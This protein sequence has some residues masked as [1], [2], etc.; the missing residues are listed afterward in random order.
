MRKVPQYVKDYWKTFV[1]P[2]KSVGL[3]ESTMMEIRRR[4]LIEHAFFAKCV[5]YTKFEPTVHDEMWAFWVQKTGADVDF[6]TFANGITETHT[7]FLAAPRNGFKST[8]NMIDKAQWIINF[9]DISILFVVGKEDRGREFLAELKGYFERQDDGTPKIVNGEYSLFQ[10]AFPEFCVNGKRYADSF[11]VPCR[12]TAEGARQPTISFAG[13]ETSMSG[14]HFDI[15][16]FDDAVTNENSR[17]AARLVTIRN[18]ISMHRKMMNPYGFCDYIGTWYNPLDHYG[19]II[20]AEQDNKTLF[21]TKGNCDSRDQDGRDAL[22][23]IMLRCAMW[24]K[25]DKDID[26]DGPIEEKD[27]VLWFP[28]RLTWKWLMIERQNRETFHSQLMNNPNLTKS[29]RFQRAIMTKY[30]KPFMEMPEVGGGYGMVVQCWDTAYTDNSMSN[31]TVGITALILGGRY[32][33]LDMVRGQFS[34]YDIARVM[35]ENMAK[36]KP[37][38]IVLEECNGIH[39]L[40][41]EI[42]RELERMN[43]YVPIEF[44][45][46]ENTKNRKSVLAAPVAK[47]FGEGRMIV[48]NGMPYLDQFYTELEGFQNGAP[49]DD[50]VDALS[51]LVHY[52]QYI[53]EASAMALKS[54]IQEEMDRRRG[55]SLYNHIYGVNT[56]DG[57]FANQAE[58][59]DA[60]EI[61]SWVAYDPSSNWS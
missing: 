1:N 58:R 15:I 44:A 5:G 57:G 23:K 4:C 3:K 43:T 46:I 21:W 45:E 30:T 27:W 48:S 31:F 28:M 10:L 9:P 8:T 41:R 60:E 55:R 61:P 22:T 24:P 47:L 37:S 7:R 14:P 26:I 6:E 13:V 51:I 17:T 40:A 16:A 34:D 38:R 50:I 20:K 2:D 19:F 54:D 12:T 18:Q 32:Y 42:R 52:F 39:W 33:L 25:G 56:G 49:N 53:P 59:R 29:V 36:W 11:T 35:A